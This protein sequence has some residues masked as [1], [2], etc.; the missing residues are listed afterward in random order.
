[1]ISKAIIKDIQNLAHKESRTEQR[2]F[3]AEGNKWAEE[4][5]AQA[6][7]QIRGIY[8]LKHWMD[9]HATQVTGLPVQEVDAVMMSRLSQRKTPTEVLIVVKQFSRSPEPAREGIHLV[10]STIQDPG[11]LG[12]II[13][14]ADW[15]G[16]RQ[17]VCSHDCADQYNPKVVQATMSSLIRVPVVYASLP[18]W[19]AQQ[20][21]IRK[22]AA[23]LHGADY[24]KA[25]G[26][27]I[28]MMG[29]ESK[30]L[31]EEL[32]ALATDT[33]TIPRIGMAESLNVSVASGILLSQLTR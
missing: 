23:V 21:H 18:E 19:L 30:G 31:S 32:L 7:Q 12:T 14:T 20:S 28:L 15:F 9:A 8:A 17:V 11:N 29:N 13:R 22:W 10:L 26:D 24:T 3:L 27:G 4:L 6:P 25:R 16:V 33:I 5:L 1:M 2:L